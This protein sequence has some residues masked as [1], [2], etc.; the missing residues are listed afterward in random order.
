MYVGRKKSSGC[1]DLDTLVLGH[2]GLGAA[3]ADLAFVVHVLVL[4][5]PL[6]ITGDGRADSTQV[7]LSAVLDTMTPVLELTLGFLL[8]AGGV[9][10][11]T[12]LAKA[13]VADGVTDGLLG[14]ADGLIP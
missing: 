3:L 14:G 13:L 12:R 8:L 2:I 6:A 9:L 7:A 11:S 4:L 5:L 10:L 1:T